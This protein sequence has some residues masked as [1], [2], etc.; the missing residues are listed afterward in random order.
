[1][2]LHRPSIQWCWRPPSHLPVQSLAIV[3]PE[4][5][6]I[7][8]YYYISIKRCITGQTQKHVHNDF[9]VFSTVFHKISKYF[10]WVLDN[11]LFIK[12]SMAYSRKPLFRCLFIWQ[13]N[14]LF[15]EG[16]LVYGFCFVLFFSFYLIFGVYFTLLTA[17]TGSGWCAGT[18][19]IDAVNLISGSTGGE[20]V[21]VSGLSARLSGD[22]K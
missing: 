22:C 18:L 14:F 3:Q 11:Y 15:Y 5:N 20:W 2:H 12:I 4:S 17:G 9:Q 19:T 16:R 7:N 10:H 21:A 13:D 6:R 8:M 1:M